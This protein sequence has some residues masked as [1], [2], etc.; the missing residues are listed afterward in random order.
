M[1]YG[2][3]MRFFHCTCALVLA[4]AL[5]APAAAQAPAAGDSTGYSVFLRGEPI[6]RENVSVRSDAD[7]LTVVTEGRV[8]APADLLIRRAEFRYATDWTP[9]SFVLEANAGGEDVTLRTTVKD[10]NAV[11]EGTQGGRPVSITHPVSRQAVLHANGIFASYVALA[12]RLVGTPA[13]SE[14]RLY[15][16]PQAEI[17]VR[18]A[19]V[20]DERMQIGTDFLDVRRYELVFTNPGGELT[21]HLTTDRE[22]RL[23]G[24][25]IPGQSLNILR[26]DLTASTARTQVYSN[27]GDEP[28]TIPAAGFNLGGTITRPSTP[29]PGGRYAAVIFLSGSGADDRDGF[30]SGIPMIGQLAGAV[31]QAGVLAVRYD[32]RGYGQSGGRAESASITDAAEDARAVMRW[33]AARK[34]VDPRRIALVGHAEGAWVALLAAARERRFAAVVSLAGAASAGAALVL[35]QQQ[36]A[37][38]RLKL[39]PEERE[40]RVALQKQIQA[41]VLTGKGWNAIPADVRK[42][43]DTP[44]FQSL[45][46]Y[47]PM[48]V[49]EDVRQPMLFVHG[50]LDRQVPVE[51]ADRLA[52]LAKAESRSPSIEVVIVR[53]VNH[54]LV[55]A[56]TGEPGEYATLTDRMVS[57][58]VSSAITGWLTRT[59]QSVK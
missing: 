3:S 28:V 45:L 41:A 36:R 34:D 22:G 38:D 42:Q 40:K 26:A 21:A 43:A 20:N 16:V 7:G 19:A 23:V 25:S 49:I 47:N 44:W 6:G 39:P 29:P 37:L 13:G 31:A 15:V 58:D 9:M 27:P 32:K 14:L 17:A 4:L 33:L 52:T 50:E 30:L 54:L 46:A 55:P 11:T 1:Q 35:E 48:R 8:S 2:V 18:V 53:G 5:A 10:G 56:T 12:R 57:Q 59:F 24:V 51:H